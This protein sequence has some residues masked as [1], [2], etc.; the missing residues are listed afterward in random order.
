MNLACPVVCAALQ[1]LQKVLQQT[2]EQR[3]ATVSCQVDGRGVTEDEQCAALK[4]L[5]V[6][7]ETVAPQ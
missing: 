2:A 5:E 1:I 6:S 4:V 3:E 7:N